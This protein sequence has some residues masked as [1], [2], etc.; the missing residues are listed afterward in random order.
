MHTIWHL[1][2]LLKEEE[3][4]EEC[5]YSTQ[6]IDCIHVKNIVSFL[7]TLS[8]NLSEDHNPTSS[9]FAI[10][11]AKPRLKGGDTLSIE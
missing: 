4:E 9:D 7:V 11:G 1:R 6:I 3:Y 5:E 8:Q 10:Y 2:T